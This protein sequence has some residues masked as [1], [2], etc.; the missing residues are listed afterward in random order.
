LTGD[1]ASSFENKFRKDLS[2]RPYVDG[3]KWQFSIAHTNGILALAFSEEVCV[4]IDIEARDRKP[5]AQE[6]SERFFNSDEN[7][8]LKSLDEE[9]RNKNFLKIWTAKEAIFKCDQTSFGSILKSID[10]SEYAKSSS[11]LRTYIL[12]LESDFLSL[13]SFQIA[14]LNLSGALAA[15]GEREIKPQPSLQKES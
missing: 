15:K 3:S 13:M 2:G 4:G 12:R 1:T 5:R 10:L 6:I 14:T 7:A 11:D 9:A 8:W